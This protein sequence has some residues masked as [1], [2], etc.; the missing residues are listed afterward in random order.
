MKLLTKKSLFL[1]QVDG[2]IGSGNNN[3]DSIAA[4]RQGYISK[5]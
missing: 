1:R 3:H 4:F 2:L 5:H